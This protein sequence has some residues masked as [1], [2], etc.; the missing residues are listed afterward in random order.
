MKKTED[1]NVILTEIVFP[2]DTNPIGIL[3][4]GKLIQWMDTASAICSQLHSN[5]ICVTASIDN[6]VFKK[7]IL[8][9]DIVTIKAKVTRAFNTS[10]EI[11]VEVLSK[12]I[13]DNTPLVTNT[14]YFTFVAL[15]K[16]GKPSPIQE[17]IPSNDIEKEEYERALLRRERRK[18]DIYHKKK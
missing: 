1:S 12:K 16:D 11:F 5:K 7:P 3:H 14:A 15:D 2:N 6:V 10:M 9:G 8:L 13:D 4:G 18:D 17:L